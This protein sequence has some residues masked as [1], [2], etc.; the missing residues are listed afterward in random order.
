MAEKL[1][2]A[3][4]RLLGAMFQAEQIADDGFSKRIVT[5]IRRRMWLRRLTLPIAMF[6]G[7]SIAIKPIAELSVVVSKL[8]TVIPMELLEAP[9]TVFPQLQYVVLGTMLLAAGL[10][11][12]RMLEE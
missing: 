12:V 6:V 3:E 9:I 8:L 7:G 5:R 2:D 11:G 1:K 10:L 4:D